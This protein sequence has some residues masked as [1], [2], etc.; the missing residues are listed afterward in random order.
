ML[1]QIKMLEINW[2]KSYMY[3]NEIKQLKQIKVPAYVA[4]FI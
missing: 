2:I 1:I 3:V 4:N